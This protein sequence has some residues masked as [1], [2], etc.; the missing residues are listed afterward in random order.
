M[1][2][3]YVGMVCFGLLQL[4]QMPLEQVEQIR[5]RLADT[6]SM[7]LTDPVHSL[8]R[9]SKTGFVRGILMAIG[10]KLLSR[11]FRDRA[12]RAAVARAAENSEKSN[13]SS[14]TSNSKRD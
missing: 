9:F 1:R 12:T 4:Y 3:M 10:L 8:Q 6:W 11:R 14:L 5:L 13:A 7:F 2:A